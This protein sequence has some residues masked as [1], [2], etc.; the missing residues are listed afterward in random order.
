MG[1]IKNAV[2]PVP[3]LVFRWST[4]ETHDAYAQLGTFSFEGGNNNYLAWQQVEEV[5]H[6]L[7][8]AQTCESSRGSETQVANVKRLYL[9]NQGAE[10]FDGTQNVVA[11]RKG[12]HVRDI[13]A[14]T[15]IK[16]M[17]GGKIKLFEALM[18]LG[19]IWKTSGGFSIPKSD[20]VNYRG[21][22]KSIQT[23]L[24]QLD[25]IDK[26][27]KS[28]EAKGEDMKLLRRR[29]KEARAAAVR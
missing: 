23:V 22:D 20:P 2:Q 27:L 16:L 6:P 11:D 8:K 7:G 12:I 9:D 4:G 26:T 14:I 3:G 18:K 17:E 15:P 19:D 13:K 25:A 5:A 29:W 24:A 21:R 10:P 1:G 28:K